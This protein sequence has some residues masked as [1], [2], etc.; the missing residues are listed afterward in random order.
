MGGKCSLLPGEVS[1]VIPNDY[2][3]VARTCEK[4]AEV[5]VVTIVMKDRTTIIL[6]NKE[7]YAQP[8]KSSQR[9]GI[10]RKATHL[11]KIRVELKNIKRVQ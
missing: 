2:S 4:S 10:D 7:V 3:D 1:Q 9:R 8:Q 11:E 5:I 6:E